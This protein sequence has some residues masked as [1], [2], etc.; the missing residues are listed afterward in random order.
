MELKHNQSV[1]NILVDWLLIVPYGIETD[2]IEVFEFLSSLL[3]V[4]YGIET[5]EQGFCKF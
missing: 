5:R 1:A 2:L 4:P 3:I